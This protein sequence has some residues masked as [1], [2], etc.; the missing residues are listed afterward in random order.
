MFE[1]VRLLYDNSLWSSLVQIAPYA[2]SHEIDCEG[3]SG[4]KRHLLLCMIGDAFFE[5]RNFKKAEPMYKE[6]I[7]LKKQI[8]IIKKSDGSSTSVEDS[9]VEGK[10]AVNSSDVEIKYKLHLCY[11]NTNQVKLHENHVFIFDPPF[12]SQEILKFWVSS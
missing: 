1:Q 2:L 10:L 4:K 8:K 12:L 7:Q 5:Q 9:Q 3:K 6:A 11:M